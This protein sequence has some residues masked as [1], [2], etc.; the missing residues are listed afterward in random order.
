[1]DLDDAALDEDADA[2]F[3]KVGGGDL[4]GGDLEKEKLIPPLRF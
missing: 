2:A 4:D 1:M 3:A